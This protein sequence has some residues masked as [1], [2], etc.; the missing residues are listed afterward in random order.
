LNNGAIKVVGLSSGELIHVLRGHAD[1]ISRLTYYEGWG[2]ISSSLD[3][4]LR[5]WDT[6]V[7]V[8]LARL[9]EHNEGVYCL[10]A[11]K[12]RGS[13][14]SGSADGVLKVWNTDGRCTATLHGHEAEV[15]C[16]VICSFSCSVGFSSSSVEAGSKDGMDAAGSKD[17]MDESGWDRCGWI[18]H[19]RC[20]EVGWDS[21]GCLKNQS[22]PIPRSRIHPSPFSIHPP[23]PLL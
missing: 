18:V 5:V 19:F 6:V 16:M 22:Y 8:C 13:I 2:V 23:P 15:Y 4:T 12:G 7:G 20:L 17:G 11:S 14:V 3:S 1:E 10:A 9:A 21:I